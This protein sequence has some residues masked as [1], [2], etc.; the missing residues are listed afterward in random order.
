M[1]HSIVTKSS[2][3]CAMVLF[4]VSAVFMSQAIFLELSLAFGVDLARARFTFSAASL[5]YASAFFVI[6]P[7]SD[8]FNLPKMG[9]TGLLVVT[10]ALVA[11]SCASS[12]HLFI[13]AMGTLGFF[14]ALVPAS[15][16]P[17]ITRIVP[18]AQRGPYIGALV[19]SGTLGIVLGRVIMGLLTAQFGW[20]V[21]FRILAGGILALTLLSWGILVE[22]G[23]ASPQS[24]HGLATLYK[25]SFGLLAMGRP[26]LL[27]STGFL[28]FFG[29]LGMITFLTYRL[30]GAP[31]HFT[32]AE[33]GWI[34]MA[35]VTAV[36]APFSGHMAQRRGIFQIAL[37]S[38]GAA[39]LS[40]Q[41]LGWGT[42]IP[43]IIAGIL[44]LF[45]GV[46]TC[47][48]LIFLLIGRCVPQESLATASSL[49][50]LVCIGGGSLSSI[51]LGPLWLFHGWVGITLAC[52]VS[53][54]A[55]MAILIFLA[56]KDQ[57]RHQTVQATPV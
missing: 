39:L 50:I 3:A 38:L 11:A 27:F 44:I 15:M 46:Y 35:G 9:C 13:W 22:K 26:V 20:T 17:H 25:K 49:Y 45:A 51:W 24:T 23:E 6:G 33:V 40:L 52:S 1:R 10:L 8:R 42:T 21:A 36:I 37:P 55:A 19:A 48:P 54:L 30:V 31:F 29:Y 18:E 47:Q 41:L 14:A 2:M 12:F 5:S 57:V 28:L 34:S 16:F 56:W 53:L 7:I 43:M 32:S 4:A